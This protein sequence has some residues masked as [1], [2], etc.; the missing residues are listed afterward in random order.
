MDLYIATNNA[1]KV[2]E[3]T[4][5]FPGIRI[6]TPA[7]ANIRFDY[8]EV[9]DSFLG[10]SL[11]KARALHALVGAP[12]LADDSGLCVDALGGEPG[13]RSARYG[14][15]DNGE[16]KL[17]TPE[18][19]GLLLAAMAGKS[20]RRC[21]FVCAMSLVLSL[22]RFFLVQETCEGLL[23]DAPKGMGGFGYD[24]IFLLPDL[25]LSMAELS[26]EQKNSLSHR[27]RASARMR[28]ILGSLE[29]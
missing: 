4:A 14:S 17:S 2:S 27:G 24:P 15:P 6:R 29:A 10:N 8:E 12:V 20:D 13:V 7:D 28:S 26:P 11:G 3:L 16:T 19:N 23:L 18:R 22:D 5:L 21:R 1:H 25:G 9:E